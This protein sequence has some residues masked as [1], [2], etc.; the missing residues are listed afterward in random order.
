MI[1]DHTHWLSTPLYLSEV[2]VNIWNNQKVRGYFTLKYPPKGVY[3]LSIQTFPDQ[4]EIVYRFDW[5]LEL[6]FFL[7]ATF[8]LIK[9]SSVLKEMS[10]YIVQ[11]FGWYSMG[12]Y[13]SK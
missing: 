2:L 11:L 4:M 13:F 7:T 5:N 10:L 9:G 12:K 3:N 6:V 8:L 1:S